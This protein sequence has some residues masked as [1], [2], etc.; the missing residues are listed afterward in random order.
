[1]EWN[2]KLQIIIDYVENHLQRKEE[3]VNTD[4]IAQIA[5]C[6][7]SFFQKVFSYMNGIS[8]ADYVRARK[9]TLAG[10]DLKS[11]DLKVVDISFKY[12][13]DSPTSFSKAFQQF[14]GVSPK[15]ARNN[16]TILKV[17]P[18]M[19]ISAKAHY[20]W[21]IEHKSSFRLVLKST[22][23]CGRD[24]SRYTAIPGF[25][26][27]CQRN[28]S[29]AKLI[30]IDTGRPKGL[31]GMTQGPDRETGNMTYSIG[32]ESTY[33]LPESFR[34]LIIPE[35]T[36][37]V[38]DCTGP[39]PQAIQNGWKYLTEEWLLQYP[40]SHAPCPEF[41][42]YSSGNSYADDYLSQIWIPI[43]EEEK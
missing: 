2:E 10:Y 37:A 36:W 28:G 34:E 9:M 25:W 20:S 6:S 7:Y 11:T 1:M 22:D 15:D 33:A 14:H 13:Y 27:D 40:F 16:S 8:F 17:Y 3:P 42:W 23:I 19:Q 32:V 12:G 38:F 35:T 31:F 30:S 5:G 29:F 39:V 26:N 24:D 18:K 41:E 4:K 43:I 21:K